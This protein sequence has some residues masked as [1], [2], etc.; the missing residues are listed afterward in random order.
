MG[1]VSLAK[2]AVKIPN[3]IKTA[4]WGTTAVTT[5]QTGYQQVEEGVRSGESPSLWEFSKGFGSNFLPNALKVVSYPF[6]FIGGAAT[7]AWGSVTGSEQKPKENSTPAAKTGAEQDPPPPAQG[8]A[9][10]KGDGTTPVDVSKDPA[11][12]PPVT[13]DGRTETGRLATERAEKER[14]ARAEEAARAKTKGEIDDAKEEFERMTSLARDGEGNLNVW[15][16]I[17]NITRMVNSPGVPSFFRTGWNWLVGMLDT[18]L[19][20]SIML[21]LGAITGLRTAFGAGGALLRGDVKGAAAITAMGGAKTALFSGLALQHDG[22]GATAGPAVRNAGQYRNDLSQTPVVTVPPPSQPYGR[23]LDT[24]QSAN[25][26][27]TS[28]ARI[29]RND[30]PDHDAQAPG[31][32]ERGWTAPTEVPDDRPPYNPS[33]RQARLTKEGD[34]A[35]EFNIMPPAKNE[36]IYGDRYDKRELAVASAAPTFEHGYN[37]R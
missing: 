11:A 36:P 30:Y 28:A 15:A 21:A 14:R 32:R 26:P 3:L 6:T 17:N 20:R 35:R 7:G 37:G 12:Q 4:F 10:P 33:S 5:V 27:F 25:Q 2:A 23:G 8:A 24:S 13:P 31:A 34:L 1:L 18:D 22:G 19:G 9:P 16:G 29:S